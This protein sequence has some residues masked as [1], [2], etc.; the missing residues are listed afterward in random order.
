MELKFGKQ[1]G[2][3]RLTRAE[4]QELADK[5]PEWIKQELGRVIKQTTDVN[6]SMVRA[7]SNFKDIFFVNSL[8]WV[9][10]QM[11]ST[12]LRSNARYLLVHSGIESLA[13]LSKR[14]G[15]NASF[16]WRTLVDMDRQENT[17]GWNLQNVIVLSS[18]FG[19]SPAGFLFA[20]FQAATTAEIKR[21]ENTEDS[22]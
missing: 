5:G 15:M 18:A 12:R 13:E 4:E 10:A 3:Y 11:E 7:V 2:Q 8:I 16:L 19:I 1:R 22:I 20:D 9:Y 21:F 14:T 17:G 6:M